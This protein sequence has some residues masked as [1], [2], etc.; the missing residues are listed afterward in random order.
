[1]T[2]ETIRM[3]CTL[4]RE[5]Y[6]LFVAAMHVPV[7]I[8]G[9]AYNSSSLIASWV[10]ANER[11]NYLN[12]YAYTAPD[13]LFSQRP[14][15]LRLA[16]NKGAGNIAIARRSPSCR[17][18][19]KEWDFE[20]TVLPEEVLDFL[21]WVVSLVETKT[22]GLRSSVQ[23]TPLPVVFKTSNITLTTEAWTHKARQVALYENRVE[24]EEVEIG[25]AM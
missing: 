20:L 23:E 12:I 15:I 25:L 22:K 19:N 8:S 17:G 24:T 4:R 9:S 13:E 21:P 14:F 18:L 16:I 7:K 2:P 6:S 3:I 10:D 5:F 1:V 11:L